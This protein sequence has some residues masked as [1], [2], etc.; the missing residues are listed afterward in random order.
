MLTLVMSMWN[1]FRPGTP[2]PSRSACRTPQ[3]LD[4]GPFGPGGSGG[5]APTNSW[6]ATSTRATPT[7]ATTTRATPTRATPTL[8]GLALVGLA[9]VGLALVGLLI[10]GCRVDR[11]VTTLRLGHGLDVAHPVH[12]AMVHM[13]DTLEAL[14]NGTLQLALYPSQQLGTERECLELLQIG[15]LGL[16][17]VSSSVLEGFAPAY[18]VFGLPYVFRDDAHRFAVLD[19]SI[20]D[21]ILRSSVP[22]RLRGLAYY[23]AGSRSF[24]TLEEPVQTPADLEGKKIRTQESPLAIGMVSALGGAPTPIAWGELY[25]SLQQG[26]VDGAENNPPSF[27][28]SRHY[29]VAQYYSLDEHT[30]VPDVLLVS[31]SVWDRLSPRQ[32]TWLQQA[33]DASAKIQRRLWREA[34]VEAMDAV[35]A[36][37]VTILRPDKAPFVAKVQE[38]YVPFRDDPT[39]GPLLARIEALRD[40]VESPQTGGDSLASTLVHD[41]VRDTVRAAGA[42]YAAAAGTA[43]GKTLAAR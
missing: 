34:T 7:R 15:S 3:G 25:T 43:S 23:D 33:A 26:V 28:L 1:R 8:T 19:G 36:A 31:T 12:Q 42:A 37:G 35:E 17:K 11:P 4:G 5:S 18:Q 14:S 6:R 38:M 24:Y 9:L 22:Q 20:G 29:E 27:Y 10:G 30:A 13:A 40:A 41:T 2:R 39:V 32:R 21:D 16:T